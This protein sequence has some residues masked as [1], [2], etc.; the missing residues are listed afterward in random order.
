MHK[1]HLG[2]IVSR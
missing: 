1:E 2:V